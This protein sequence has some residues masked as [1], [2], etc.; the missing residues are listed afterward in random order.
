MYAMRLPDHQ[1]GRFPST[2]EGLKFAANS[3]RCLL[4][5]QAW[6]RKQLLWAHLDAVQAFARQ[7]EA[8]FFVAAI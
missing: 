3:R 2:D 8:T 4:K 5:R 1:E 6:D 7:A